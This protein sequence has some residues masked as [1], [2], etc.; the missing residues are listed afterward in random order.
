MQKLKTEAVLATGARLLYFHT[1]VIDLLVRPVH[2]HF[3][4]HTNTY[5]RTLP[6]LHTHSL[7]PIRALSHSYTRT[8]SL[9][10]THSLTPI[11]ALSHSYTRTLSL[12]HTQSLTPTHAHTHRR[13]ITYAHSHASPSP[14]CFHSCLLDRIYCHFYYLLVVLN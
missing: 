8:L 13:T 10:Y 9:L 4:I 11:H 2:S 7:T 1:F 14:P 5:T 3:N 6:H 12:L